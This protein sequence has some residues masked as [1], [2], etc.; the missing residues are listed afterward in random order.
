MIA[1]ASF[2][3][4]QI[5]G[6]QNDSSRITQKIFKEQ[7]RFIGGGILLQQSLIDIR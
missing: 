3:F 6:V 7:S 2:L 1:I 5:G 4:L